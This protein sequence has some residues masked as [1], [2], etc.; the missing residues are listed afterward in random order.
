MS[1]EDFIRK[2]IIATLVGEGFPESVARGGAEYGLD[3]YRRSSQASRKGAIFDDCLFRSA[4]VVYRPDHLRRA[5]S[6]QEKAGSGKGVPTRPVLTAAM[7]NDSN[8]PGGVN[9]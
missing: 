6:N 1:P 2:H 4:Q 7:Q 5:K 9:S 8:L 3:Y